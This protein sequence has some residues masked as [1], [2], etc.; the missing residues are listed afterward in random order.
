MIFQRNLDSLTGLLQQCRK[1]MYIKHI[2]LTNEFHQISYRVLIDVSVGDGSESFFHRHS[3]I[4]WINLEELQGRGST[5][6]REPDHIV[7]TL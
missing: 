6:G 3:P 2:Y 5:S 1:Y 7:G 4:N